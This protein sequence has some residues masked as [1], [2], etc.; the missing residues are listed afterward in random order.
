LPSTTRVAVMP[1]QKPK[2]YV[3]PA[4]KPPKQTTPSSVDGGSKAVTL[5][6]G[7]TLIISNGMSVKVKCP[8]REFDR[9][10]LRWTKNGKPLKESKNCMS[11]TYT[12]PTLV[13]LCSKSYQNFQSWC[14][15][16]IRREAER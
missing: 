15:A 9:E 10:H 7:T 6:I 3:K 14:I 2:Q 5:K 11:C 13:S 12:L 4:K 16:Y 1:T 8:I